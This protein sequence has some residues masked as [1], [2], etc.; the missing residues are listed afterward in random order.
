MRKG[1]SF[2]RVQRC[3]PF[4]VAFPLL[5][6]IT[7]PAQQLAYESPAQTKFLLYTPPGY[8]TSDADYPLLISLHSKGELGDDLTLLTSRN[9][10]QM[11]SRLIYMNKWPAALPFVVLTPQLKPDENGP[12]T[13]WPAEYIDEVVEYVLANFRI[14]EQRIYLTGISRGGTGAW[15][16]ASA[17]PEKIAAMVPI[18]G[19]SDLTQACPIRNIPVWAFHGDGDAV[20]SATYSIDMINAIKQCQPQGG[21]TP[22]LDLL[23]A[24]DHNGWNDI[25][26]GTSGYD[27][28]S[29]LQLFRK[30]DTAN[31]KPYVDAGR[32]LRLQLRST[33]IH[34]YGDFFDWDGTIAHVS[35]TQIS[36]ALLELAG[37]TTNFLQITNPQTGT[38]GFQL[39]VTDNL[40]AQSTDIVTVEITDSAVAPAITDLVLLDGKTNIELG[41]LSE[42]QIID[43][44]ALG[45]SEINIKAVAS[46]GT[47]SVRFSVNSDDN[48]RLRNTD[49]FYIKPQS[50][51]PEWQVI[52]REY[53]ICAT[54]YPK[55]YGGG[56][57][58]VSLCYRLTVR[59]GIPSTECP[60][61]G[62]ITREI[63]TGIAGRYTSLIP[64]DAA[65]SAV[66]ELTSFETPRNSGDNYGSRVRGYVCAPVTGDYLFWIASDDTGELWLSTDENPANKTRIAYVA[67]WTRP[68]EWT[69]YSTQQSVAINLID[70]IRY[71][72]EAL[73]KEASGGDHLAVGWTLPDGTLER[74]IPGSRLSRYALEEFSTA[75]SRIVE[76]QFQVYPNPALERDVD[77]LHFSLPQH[78]NVVTKKNTIQLIDVRGEVLFS[79]E[80]DCRNDC[81]SG[82]LQLVQPLSPGVYLVVL[83]RDGKR[84]SRRLLVR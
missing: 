58:G 24:R 73:F 79:N 48:T 32:D 65:P 83:L 36:G 16:Y 6:A 56:T 19:R 31:K 72:I 4:L 63:W 59:D 17:F 69:K 26:N 82:S 39:I 34:I 20:A 76:E 11:P 54:A 47:A 57:P 35:W 14:D 12:E 13:Q 28:W 55:T 30:N 53:V 49:A 45:L 37:V 27:I 66:A 64:V 52:P 1:R 51:H 38:F 9:R 10:E 5:I 60:G 71:Y 78:G 62:T 41:N 23:N 70:G 22:R 43:K 15:T 33:P 75:Q 61:V 81:R 21:F 29:W 40:G 50:T 3:M 44:K 67:G 8:T 77:R 42:G 18:S 80:V 68:Q 74:P 46:V 2:R 7:A 84:F 25:Y